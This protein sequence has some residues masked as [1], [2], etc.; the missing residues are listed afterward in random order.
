MKT[1]RFGIIGG[2]LM[3]REIASATA[4]WTHLTEP[5]AKVELVSVCSRSPAS[6]SWFQS[7][8]PGVKQYT[9][10]YKQVLASQDV[11][12]LYIAVPHHLH[13]EMYVAAIES[14]KHLLGEKPFGIDQSANQAI[15][16][17]ARKNPKTLVRCSSEFPFFPGVQKIG[18][19]LESG[20]FGR[21]IEL[22]A[23]FL[24]SSDL[25]PN[26]PLNWKRQVEFN[27]EYGVMGDLGMHILH[28]PLRAGFVIQDVR[29]ILSKIISHRPDGK[30]GT[31]PCKTW[32][33][34]TLL[35]TGRDR[36][37]AD[38]PMTLKTHR[39]SPGQRNTWSLEILGTKASARWS[40]LNPK[41]LELLEYKGADQTWQHIQTAFDPAYKTITGANFEFGFTD[42][43][44]QMWAAFCDE[45]AG[46]V[47]T[48]GC[49]T[50]EEAMESHRLFTAALE[51]QR[52]TATVALK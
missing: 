7:N 31:A 19:L 21:I 52:N 14:G 48:Y 27:G 33:N 11:D 5:P 40:T 1:I 24:H 15:L 25:D 18:A 38:F 20:A 22:Q 30:G 47:P 26:K 39:I 32:D 46:N 36:Q 17:A 10:D 44:L 8:F 49:V 6:F 45:L 9:T 29:A 16:A 13:Q 43:M 37:G 2:G 3:G 12:A 35:C 34:A 28:V 51:S 41:L 42:A 23:S 4:R 50:P